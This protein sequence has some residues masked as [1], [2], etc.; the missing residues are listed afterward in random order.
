LFLPIFWILTLD[1]FFMLFLALQ[2]PLDEDYAITSSYSV[3]EF[4]IF[5][6][7]AWFLN[8]LTLHSGPTVAS[9]YRGVFIQTNTAS[10]QLSI[11]LDMHPDTATEADVV[12]EEGFSFSFCDGLFLISLSLLLLFMR[13]MPFLVVFHFCSFLLLP[14]LS[15]PI[16]INMFEM[17]PCD[18]ISTVYCYNVQV[19]RYGSEKWLS[20]WFEPSSSSSFS[21]TV[22]SA[23]S[24]GIEIL[25]AHDP[26][27]KSFIARRVYSLC[28]PLFCLFF[29]SMIIV[30][31][32]VSLLALCLTFVALFSA[33]RYTWKTDDGASWYVAGSAGLSFSHSWTTTGSHS[34]TVRAASFYGDI[35]QRNF[36]VTIT[37][38]SA[39]PELSSVS[40]SALSSSSTE[41]P[42]VM[43]SS[44]SLASAYSDYVVSCSGQSP[45]LVALTTQAPTTTAHPPTT[46]VPPT[47]TQ[48]P[49]TT[50]ERPTTLAPTTTQAPTTTTFQPSTKYT[51]IPPITVPP[52]TT[53]TTQKPTTTPSPPVTTTTQLPTTTTQKPSTTAYILIPPVTVPPTSTTTTQKPTTTSFQPSIAFSLIPPL[54]IPR[55][56]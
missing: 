3:G 21:G 43:H 16:H 30:H 36:T 41:I 32:Q 48:K 40:S 25:T 29:S 23:V 50:I 9:N 35:T 49:T 24:M 15:A 55:G 18:S 12:L 2:V 1:P 14:P 19:N 53:T 4:W 8:P 28:L 17:A 44:L 10:T 42:L 56:H 31:F 5:A 52:I 20:I 33:L 7:Q 39:I 13:S 45:V 34:V 37:S 22:N 38:T 54:T 27:G 46:T 47:T 11:L 26:N 6:R 51:L